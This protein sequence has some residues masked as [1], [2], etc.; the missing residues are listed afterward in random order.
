LNKFHQHLS[1][2]ENCKNPA[3]VIEANYIDFLNNEKIKPYKGYFAVKALGQIQASHPRLPVIFA[4]S[5]KAAAVWSYNFFANIAS[6]VK[7]QAGDYLR[8]SAAK[9]RPAS[10]NH[11]AEDEIRRKVF[12]EMP[13]KFTTSQINSHFPQCNSQFVRQ[14]LEKLKKEGVLKNFKQGRNIVWQKN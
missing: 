2:L 9:Y 7:D 4:G 6:K 12:R 5:R 10:R 11:F 3:L 14:N 1:E 13:D 8:E